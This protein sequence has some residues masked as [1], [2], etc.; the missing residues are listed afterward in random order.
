M[1]HLST[2]PATQSHVRDLAPRVRA[3]DCAE[4]WATG[5]HTP[6]EALR[7]SVDVS[8]ASVAALADGVPFAIFGVAARSLMSD[9]GVPWLLGSDDLVTHRRPFL[10][11]GR[12]FVSAMLDI[13]PHLE[14]YVDARNTT[15]IEWLRWLGFDILPAEPF[16]VYRLPFHRFEMR[17]Q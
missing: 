7:L 10:R 12:V 15:S 13:F 5:R 17:H 8:V 4:V 16:G 9:T 2:V 6:A 14:N 1:V 3:S 11:H